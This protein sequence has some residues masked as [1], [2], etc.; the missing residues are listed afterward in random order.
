MNVSNQHISYLELLVMI[1]RREEEVEG[2]WVRQPGNVTEG[3]NLG[4]KS[5]N[6]HI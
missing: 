6:L 1:E 3:Y 4:R 2:Q 5:G